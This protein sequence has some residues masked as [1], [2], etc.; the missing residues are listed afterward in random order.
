MKSKI[1]RYPLVLALLLLTV[2]VSAQTELSLDKALEYALLHNENVLNAELLKT[3]ADAQV[4]ETRADGLPQITAGFNYTN[5]LFIAKSPIPTS[6]ITGDPNAEGVTLV[7]FGAQHV[8]NLS[9]NA[10][11]MLWDGSFFI[12]LKAAKVLRD[13]VIIDKFKAEIDVIENVTKAYYLVLVN[14]TRIDLIESNIA[15]LDSTLFETRK[16][17]ENGFAEKIDVSRLQV[18]MNNLKA[19]KSGVVQA[20]KTSKDLLKLSMGMPVQDEILLT[21][22]LE[23]LNFGYDSNEIENFSLRSRVEV[24][25]LDYLK[26]LA[27]LQIKNTTSQYIPKVSFNAGWGRNTGSNEFSNFF[28]GTNWFSNSAIGLNVS[29]PVFD[30][31]RKKYTIQRNRIELETLNNQYNL[32]TNS[33]Q[34]ELITSK[35][36]LDVSL[37]QL[38]VQKANMELAQEVSGITREKYKAGVGSNIEVINAEKDYK[39]AEINYLTAL[40]NAI[41]AKVDLDKSLGKL[42]NNDN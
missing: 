41:I 42:K 30:G 19:E 10:E 25:Q 18:Q 37:E 26:N 29:I 38:E 4:Y 35:N 7:A 15:T 23:A 8:G 9:I 11:Q 6:F 1:N 32:L 22:R 34:N 12:G 21:D 13:K 5:N 39:E 36:N 14:Q 20:V 28:T 3:D 33:L 2:T 16:L 31:L 40:Y 24:Q 27:E 17:Y